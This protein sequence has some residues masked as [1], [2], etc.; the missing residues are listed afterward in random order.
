MRPCHFSTRVES[1][2][3]D[4]PARYNRTRSRGNRPRSS[5]TPSMHFLALILGPI[6]LAQTLLAVACMKRY[7]G[8]R[9][10]AVVLMVVA[11]LPI[12]A[13]LF[14]ESFLRAIHV[15][16]SFDAVG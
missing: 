6:W 3:A 13:A 5:V 16:S 9:V 11:P 2:S 8:A 15:P 7:P 4:P 10:P 1:H 12:A 14:G